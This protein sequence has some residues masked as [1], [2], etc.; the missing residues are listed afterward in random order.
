VKRHL[1]GLY[2]LTD[3][4]Y[5]NSERAS[6]YGQRV[7]KSI[8]GYDA[9]HEMV[10]DFLSD[11]LPAD[12]HVLIAGV[13]T[14]T[15]L[16]LLVEREPGWKFTA[17][18]ISPEMLSICRKTV[19]F[20]KMDGRVDLIEGTV[21]D[22]PPDAHYD[23]ALALLV[24]QFILSPEERSNFFR[25]IACH[26]PQDALFCMADLTGDRNTSRFSMYQ[27]AWRTHNIVN[28]RSSQE[29]DN[30]FAISD[31]A[32]SIL[33]ENDYRDMLNDAGFKVI[34]LFYR[35]FLVTGWICRRG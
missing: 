26:L 29:I 9:L 22:L 30:E 16:V 13:G 20:A 23:G 10:Y 32:V 7:R 3:S 8:P 33:G 25:E 14:G 12:A 2:P 31:K 35:A 4:A 28:G 21:D 17:F 34:G 18:D 6:L 15:E 27:K 1:K 19:H 11:A 24:S 5:F